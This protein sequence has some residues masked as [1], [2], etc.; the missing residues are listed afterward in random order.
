MRLL[1]LPLLL[2]SSSCSWNGR[3]ALAEGVVEVAT[4]RPQ[5]DLDWRPLLE[6]DSMGALR[7]W[8]QVNC[9][10]GTFRFVKSE[11]G[12]DVVECSGRPSG[13]LRSAEVYENFVCEFEWR[14]FDRRGMEANAGFFIWS[15]ALP[16]LGEP[17]P[18]AIEIQVC[19][20]DHN[21]DWYSRHGDV[22]AIHG[23]RLT[24]DPR[25]AI[26]RRGMRSLPLEFRAKPTGEWNHYRITAI[27][28]VIQLEVNGKLVSGG[29]QASPRQ[30]HLMLESEGGRVQFR[31]MKILRLPSD[32]RGLAPSEK[33]ATLDAAVRVRPLF[34]GNL[35]DWDSN[36]SWKAEVWLL[37]PEKDAAEISRALPEGDASLRLDFHL[38]EAG[39]RLP[40]HL[41]L[42]GW[43]QELPITSGWHRAELQLRG[44]DWELILDGRSVAWGRE[45]A[46]PR[47][48][49]LSPNPPLTRFAS[50]LWV[51]GRDP[52]QP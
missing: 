44:G 1:F 49:S 24:P 35:D 52:L 51:Y 32:P 23:S 34:A 3:P 27:D 29:Y 15:D 45:A 11:D 28:G 18:R 10:A 14:H 36:G 43:P 21:T 4:T 41:A 47:S 37:S 20:F 30:G 50:L 33:A 17:F 22:F 40:F 38:Q 13:V 39:G 12:A 31:K 8:R 26:W 16:A 48:L 42:P 5:D 2:L 25:F 7:D 9:A 6:K 46:G 19:N